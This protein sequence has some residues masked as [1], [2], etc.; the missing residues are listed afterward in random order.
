[1][2]QEIASILKDRLKGIQFVEVLAVL[3]H[4]DEY[5]D[6][7]GSGRSIRKAIP[8]SHDVDVA[9]GCRITPERELM[10]D[11]RKKRILYLKDLGSRLIDRTSNASM[12]Y[13]SRMV[14]VCSMNR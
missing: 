1:M 5:T 7:D 9:K 14:L 13:S 10:P 3:A 6:N 11:R 8:V 12:T 4:R 2:N